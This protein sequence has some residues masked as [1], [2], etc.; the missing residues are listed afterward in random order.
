MQACPTRLRE[1]HVQCAESLRVQAYFDDEVDGVTAAEI[2]RHAEHCA[3]C[4]SLLR[5]L[6]LTRATIRRDLPHHRAPP[7]LHAQVA[8]QL[9]AELA[10]PARGSRTRRRP[11]GRAWSFW[12]GAFGGMGVTVAAAALAL[13]LLSPT[14]TNPIPEQL[15]DAHISSLMPQHLVDIESTDHHTVKPWFA[16]Q[17]DV[18]PV[19]ADFAQQGYRLVGGR[20]DYLDRQRAAALVY[21]HGPHVINVFSWAG[22]A[23]GLPSSTTRN[24]YHMVFWQ[25]GD[26]QYCAVSDAGWNE[27]HALVRLLQELGAQEIRE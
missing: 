5:D 3:A 23:R 4:R 2:E 22:N 27:L 16:G 6:E 20:A 9:D 21:R 13:V 18:S 12:A 24:G 14:L 17:T 11:V 26:L 15:V 8:R 7:V 25:V 1:S 19:V 10:V